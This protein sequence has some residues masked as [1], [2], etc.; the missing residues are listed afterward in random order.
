MRA[1]VLDTCWPTPGYTSPHGMTHLQD[2][3]TQFVL[4]VCHLAQARRLLGTPPPPSPACRP[5]PLQPKSIPVLLQV[6]SAK[7]ELAELIATE[8][9]IRVPFRPRDIGELEKDV[10]LAGKAKEKRLHPS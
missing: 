2:A 10:E 8:L 4:A 5:T 6:L 9:G 3:P 7:F 1:L